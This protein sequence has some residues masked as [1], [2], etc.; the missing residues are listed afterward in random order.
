M[1]RL[2]MKTRNDLSALKW[3]L[4][5]WTPELWRIQKPVE[6]G[7]APRAEVSAIPAPTP[8]SVQFALRQAGIIPDWNIGFNA[9]SCEWVENRQWI[10]EVAIPDA[11]LS[12]GMIHRLVCEGLDYC[13]W[14]LLNGREVAA[15]HGS[16]IPHVVDLTDKLKES[17]NILQIVFDLPPRWLGQFGRTSNVKEWKVRYYYTWD[18]VARLV[19]QGI[20][21]KVYFDVSDGAEIQ[22]LSCATDV[23]MADMT[24]TLD[25][26]GRIDG[27]TGDSVCVVL[28]RNG[29]VVR[30]VDLTLAEFNLKGIHWKELP[31]ELWWPN[32]SGGQPL[33]ELK[34]TVINKAGGVIDRAARIVG[35]KNVQW[36][37]C[38]D[39]PAKAD[40]WLCSINGQDTFLQGANWIPVRVNFA[41]VTE[42]QYRRHLTLY[43]DLGFNLL[44]VWGG[45][46]LEKEIFYRLCDELGLMVWQEFPLSSSGVDDYPPED[47]LAIQEMTAIAK[48]YIARRHHHVSL[49]LWCGGNELITTAGGAYRPVDA[50]HPM[51]RALQST[52]KSMDPV[53]RFLVTSPSG[54]TVHRNPG[55]FG[56]G[57]HWDIHGPWKMPGDIEAW[58]QY[59][60]NDDAL[61]R[62]EL[63]APGTASVEMIR[64]YAGDHDPL[65]IARG[66]PLW[67]YP[68]DW[69]FEIDPFIEEHKRN[70]LTLEEYVTWSQM[71]QSQALSI[72]IKACKDRFPRC[73]GFIIWEGHDCFPC[74]ANTA[75]IDFEGN[76]KPAALAIKKIL[77][78][79]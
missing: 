3:K 62:S 5:G 14:F 13:G 71:R 8:G 10:Y 59:W 34:L 40:P 32:L 46:I 41:D 18:W 4:S 44:R 72:A 73:G 29:Q 35:F 16:H 78:R 39:A 22:E 45:A 48:T 42:A 11:W 2:I 60:L 69:W 36:K 1:L 33:F 65:P 37:A 61:F 12:K 6:V 50:T 57:L 31:I 28:E 64:K 63:G 67:K 27:A 66:N 51:I 47:P 58:R 23:A 26:K 17:G 15:F 74:V 19:Q 7:D 76:L 52:T 56:Q 70:P 20:W 25:L 38:Q 53:H 9:R 21:D 79:A 54:P 68:I 30:K 75:I 77:R 24:G 49:L 55:T 43:R